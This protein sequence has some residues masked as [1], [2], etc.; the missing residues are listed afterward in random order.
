MN[1]NSDLLEF[2][3]GYEP[4]EAMKEMHERLYP[5]YKGPVVN[6]PE[7]NPLMF[8]TELRTGNIGNRWGQD[9]SV[10]ALLLSTNAYNGQLDPVVR[11]DYY[12]SRRRD[13]SAC[14]HGCLGHQGKLINLLI[15]LGRTKMVEYALKCGVGLNAPSCS[16][17]TRTILW[18]NKKKVD[19]VSAVR[20][21]GNKKSSVEQSTDDGSDIDTDNDLVDEVALKRSEKKTEE[22][23][24]P[25]RPRRDSPTNLSM[26]QEPNKGKNKKKRYKGELPPPTD[27]AGINDHD[28]THIKSVF[29]PITP[30]A[31]AVECAIAK[32]GKVEIVK[33]LLDR[34][35]NPLMC[36]G[37]GL[38]YCIPVIDSWARSQ[39]QV[40]DKRKKSTSSFSS[41]LSFDKD[42]AVCLD[43]VV[44]ASRRR[45]NQL[46]NAADFEGNFATIAVK[47]HMMYE[48]L[49][50]G[51]WDAVRFLTPNKD[52][53]VQR[54]NTETA[55]LRLNKSKNSVQGLN[56]TPT[57]ATVLHKVAEVLLETALEDA[58]NTRAQKLNGFWFLLEEFKFYPTDDQMARAYNVM[59]LSMA[60]GTNSACAGERKAIVRLLKNKQMR[61]FF[62]L[63]LDN[64]WAKKCLDQFGFATKKQ[65]SKKQGFSLSI[66]GSARNMRHLDNHHHHQTSG[67]DAVTMQRKL[68]VAAARVGF[69]EVLDLLRIQESHLKK[70]TLEEILRNITREYYQFHLYTRI[71]ELYKKQNGEAVYNAMMKKVLKKCLIESLESKFESKQIVS[72]VERIEIGEMSKD[73]LEN[74]FSDEAAAYVVHQ[75]LN[76]GVELGTTHKDLQLYTGFIY[77]VITFGPFYKQYWLDVNPALRLSRV[78]VFRKL[79]DIYLENTEKNEI[80]NFIQKISGDSFRSWDEGFH[81]LIRRSMDENDEF[82]EEDSIVREIYEMETTIKRSIDFDYPLIQI[83]EAPVQRIGSGRQE[84]DDDMQDYFDRYGPGGGDGET[85]SDML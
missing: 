50:R 9:T 5:S 78:F 62:R 22:Q 74:F 56:F 16:W 30:L 11:T 40:G 53:V 46:P 44:R 82:A 85:M 59:I 81:F 41:V 10:D 39:S 49:M 21:N 12:F 79:V 6:L 3:Y 51:N 58:C 48:A 20:K 13:D 65:K 77:D 60:G 80:I 32:H 55:T 84:I 31:V 72:I 71:V 27:H 38:R 18:D 45:F 73:V 64:A 61:H 23:Q 24:P 54:N 70:K 4:P 63:E 47:S 15:R 35:A 69:G 14:F 7:S 37:I 25:Q 42:D 1:D 83:N 19:L 29:E 43:L 68:Y 66:Y 17:I 33:L 52:R 57:V 28:K 67:H 76:R 26:K 34:G 36:D 8:E 2:F 75:L